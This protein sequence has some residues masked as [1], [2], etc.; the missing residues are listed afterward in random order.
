MKK[1]Y[2]GLALHTKKTVFRKA[3]AL[4]VFLFFCSISVSAKVVALMDNS[5]AEATP[6]LIVVSDSAT[7]YNIQAF[8]NAEII[9]KKDDFIS[10]K[11]EIFVSEGVVLYNR[12]VISNAEIVVE[13]QSSEKLVST[14]KETNTIQKPAVV[15]AKKHTKESTFISLL[16]D[17]SVFSHHTKEACVFIHINE[18]TGFKAEPSRSYS[19][20]I[21]SF[22]TQGE[23]IT[24]KSPH[25]TIS[26][27]SGKHSVRPPTFFPEF[28]ICIDSY[29]IA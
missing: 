13:S 18:H 4:C 5:F 20:A 29:A 17:S 2:S 6:A 15:I 26:Y 10:Q 14:N 1:S 3:V 7:V 27:F 8:A 9:I 25:F 28:L 21:F 19:I 24:Y 12:E 23:K 16:K 22:T 11:A